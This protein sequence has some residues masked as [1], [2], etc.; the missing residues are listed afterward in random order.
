MILTVPKPDREPWPTL[1]PYVCEFIAENLV[2]GPG[3]LVGEPV[4]LDREKEMWIYRLYEVYPKGH[5]RAGRRRYE[6]AAISVRK[7]LAKTEFAALIAACELAPDGPVRTID[8]DSKGYPIGGPVRDPYVPMVAYTEEQTEELAYGALR[9]ILEESPIAR[10]F[11]IGLDRI[12]RRDGHGK[13]EALASSP[14]SADGA[15]TTFQH[16]DET[17]RMVLPRLKKAYST[18]LANIPKRRAADAW[19][20]ETTTAFAPGEG[21]VAE[22]TMAKAE[23]IL[24]GKTSDPA[25]FFF[26]RQASEKHNL[27]TEKGRRAAVIEATGKEALPWAGDLEKILRQLR[28]PPNG[29]RA[30][31]ERVWTNRLVRSQ[32]RAFDAV[33][34]RKLHRPNHKVQKGALITIG[35]DGARTF[36]STALVGTEVATGYQFRLGLW[37]RPLAAGD[38][39]EVPVAEV[40]EAVEEAFKF[41]KVWRLYADP[42]YWETVVAE[43]AGKHGEEVV[44]AWATYRTRAMGHAVKGFANAILAGEL[45]HDGDADY[46]RHIGNTFRRNLQIRDDQGDPLWTIQKERQDSPNKIDLTAAGILSWEAR[47]A[48][49]AA[50]K[51]VPKRSVYHG[52]GLLTV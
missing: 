42:P 46:A 27:S 33:Q 19:S 12:M 51:G 24:R 5:P 34:W 14:N 35:F 16:F 41:Y 40:N 6:Q 39:W 37:E 21:S 9:V 45:S 29:D 1:G 11:D 43:W 18:M 7:G 2:H 4:E 10:D 32:D 30:Y 20:L 48:A 23:A 49:V 25:F 36:D 50:G 17:H 26:H 8:W 13:A 38:G 47:T 22:G 44:V 28:N 15:R 52:R 3:D 31:A